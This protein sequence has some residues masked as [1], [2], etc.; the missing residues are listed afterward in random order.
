MDRWLETETL[1]QIAEQG[2]ITNAAKALGQSVSAISRNLAALEERL[3]VRLVQRTTRSLSMTEEGEAFYQQAKILLAEMLDI[4]AKA[5]R[6]ASDPSGTLRVTASTS[7]SLLHLMPLL[8]EFTKLY[9]RVSVEVLAHN[10]YQDIIENG[11]DLAIRTRRVESDSSITIRRLAE[12]RRRLVAAPAYLEQRGHPRHP[13][14]LKDHDLLIYL[15]ADD[16]L[17]LKFS[18]KD[19]RVSVQ[20]QPKVSSNEGQLLLNAALNGMGI[21]AQPS[22][23][24]Q[25][26]LDRGTLV[27]VLDNW[28]LPRLTINLAFPTRRHMPAKTR[29]FID[30][31]AERFR[32]NNY[33]EAWTS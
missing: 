10:R 31:L 21:I 16:P 27:R 6:G 28:D 9:P 17:E 8:P 4:E 12:T 33:E 13:D 5:S 24:V 32:S 15:L 3:G 26:A 30:F 19:L 11:M 18:Q 7:F 14:D 22:Y 25:D 1:V 29:L 20:V 2:S 23:I